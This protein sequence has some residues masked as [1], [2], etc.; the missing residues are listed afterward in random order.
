M[1]AGPAAQDAVTR[2]H[3]L[4]RLRVGLH[5]VLVEGLPVRPPE[6]VPALVDAKGFFRADMA[7]LGLDIALRREVRRQLRAE[8]EAQFDA[9][10]ATGLALDHVN[11]HKHFHLHPVIAAEIIAV[12]ARH[13][14]RGLRVPREPGSVLSAIEPRAARAPAWVT[15]PWAA[16]LARRARRAGLKTPDAVFGLAWSG[17]M[18][19]ARLLGLLQHLPEGRSEIYLHPATT[20]GFA[21]HASGYR[22]AEE[23]AALIAPDVIA[24]ARRDDLRQCGYADF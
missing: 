19:T 2:A 10:R 22:Y 21:G 6:R 23:L 1:V 8:I 16:L 7:R 9:F 15:A 4:P 11:A 12:G 20:D 13:G 17:A 14:I 24:A 5:V 18:T 3:K